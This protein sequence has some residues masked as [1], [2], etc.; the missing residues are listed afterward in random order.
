[1]INEYGVLGNKSEIRKINSTNVLVSNSA[2]EHQF[3]SLKN[4]DGHLIL[5]FERSK[6][7]VPHKLSS[8]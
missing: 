3:E 6:Y 4:S 8:F 5:E 7:K 2:R 1:M